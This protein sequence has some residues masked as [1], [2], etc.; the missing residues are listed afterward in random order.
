MKYVYAF[1]EGNKDMREILGGKGANLAEMTS[2]NLPVPQGFTI[3]TEACTSYYKSGE[4]LVDE[5]IEQIIDKL[6]ELESITGKKFGGGNNPLLV[7]VRSGARTS[8]PGMMDTILNLGMNDEVCETLGRITNNYRFAYDSYRRLIQMFSDVVMNL[9]KESFE[10]LFDK[11]K[12][13]KNIEVDTDL[14]ADDLKEV[15]YRYKEEYKR[16]TNNEFPTDPKKQLL[17]A[18]KAVFRSWNT[19][20]AKTYRRLN[21]IP[22]EWGTAV[23]VQMMV[24]GNIGDNSGTGVAFTR[25]PATGEKEL[26]GEYLMNA[27]GEDVVAGIRTPESI[28]TLKEVMPEC[29]KEFTRICNILEEHYRDM[30]DMEFTIENGKLYMLQTRNGKR[31]AHAAIKIAVDM[32]REGMIDKKQALLRIDAKQLDQ[33]LHPIFEEEALSKGIEIAHGLAAS[34][35]AATGKI[36]FS[37]EEIQKAYQTGEKELILVREETSPE[38]IEGMNLAQGILTVRGGMTS[39]AAVVARGM[40]TCCISGCSEIIVDASSKTLTTKSGQIYHEGDYLS[41]DGSNGVVYGGK[42]VT[43]E[44]EI[45]GDFQEFMS[46]ADN[47]RKLSIRTNADTPKDALTAKKFGAEGIGLC[48]TEHMFFE[49]ERIFNFRR[50]I[51]APNA[52]IRNDALN[53]ILPYQRSDFEGLFSAMD[54]L[55]VIIRLLDPPLH[56]FLP[57]TDEEIKELAPTLKMTFDELKNKIDSL[58]EFNPMM[59]HRGCRLD[60]TYPEIARMQ[61]RAITEAAVNVQNKGLKVKPEIMIPLIGDTKELKYVKKVLINEINKVLNERNSKV[62]YKIGTM[63]EVPRATMIADEIAHDAEFFSFGTNDLT[64][65]TYGFSRDDASK[66]LKDYYEKHIF[67]QDPFASIDEDGVGRLMD[68]ASKLARK[69]RSD[70]ELGICGEHGGDPK[71]IAFCD[72][73]NLD[74]VSCS[75]Y[76][77]P[78]ARLAASQSVI[79]TSQEQ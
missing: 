61:A 45:T 25:N 26:Y 9:P 1:H 77:I 12:I 4:V 19:P 68:L 46:W 39:H 52:E 29:F 21:D 44:A 5:I 64:Q 48:R 51:T 22:E 17:E 8:M 37:A 79:R 18:I 50:M 23:N 71:S 60:I 63:I 65:L 78:V 28:S 43:K 24:Y 47:I 53:K 70:I 41:L 13:E 34:P 10:G 66:F 69:T 38:D 6:S 33:L 32:V 56:E 76:R 67:E 54:N 14:S 59:G 36:Y 11:I 55:P 35:G 27:Q 31:T 49:K 3:S 42:L 20:R 2:L 58:K 57:H 74:Y 72:K 73:I 40:G 16:L 15:I 75:P 7:S 62:D 30:Q